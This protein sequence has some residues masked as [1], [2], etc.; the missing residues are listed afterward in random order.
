MAPVVKQVDGFM[1][2]FFCILAALCIGAISV[3]QARVTNP[4]PTAVLREGDIYLLKAKDDWQRLTHWGDVQWLCW[5]S[6]DTLCFERKRMTG[7]KD[8]SDWRGF[9]AVRDLFIATVD[10]KILR[11]FTADHFTEEPSPSPM[12]ARALFAHRPDW[13]TQ[14]Y[15]IWETIHPNIRN[16][17]LGIRGHMPDASANQR[18]TAAALNGEGP[19][20]VGLYRYPGNDAYRRIEGPHT[21]PRF[22]P[23]NV[24]YAFLSYPGDPDSCG[25]YAYEI[26][27]GDVKFILKTPEGFARIC[28]F[29]WSR[30]GYA[31]ILVLEDSAGKRDAYFYDMERKALQRLSETGDIDQASAWH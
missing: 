15:E 29:G 2:K 27:D 16:R 17:P 22:S 26:P 23:N 24:W 21:R 10:G 12:R 8:S 13:I 5:M 20:G 1:R 19:S 18:W 31:F 11:Q 3:S 28:D 9:E 6:T 14:D 4:Y 7:L 30:D 25:I